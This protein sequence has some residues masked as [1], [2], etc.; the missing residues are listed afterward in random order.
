MI[1]TCNFILVYKQAL[2]NLLLYI[3]LLGTSIEHLL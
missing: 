2:H 1:E 3:T